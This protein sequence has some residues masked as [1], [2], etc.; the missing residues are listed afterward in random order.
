MEPFWPAYTIV[1]YLQR[2]ILF[3][4]IRRVTASIFKAGR[5]NID[6]WVKLGGQAY[7]VQKLA[8]PC[9]SLFESLKAKLSA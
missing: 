4:Y 6:P 3:A 7:Q 2:Q 5:I 1:G 8:I 9:W